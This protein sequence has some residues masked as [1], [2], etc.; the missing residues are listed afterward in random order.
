MTNRVIKELTDLSQEKDTKVT[1]EAAETAAE[2]ANPEIEQLKA[3][4]EQLKKQLAEE[5]E[6]GLRVRAEYDN[7]RKRT[8]REMGEINANVRCETITEILPIAD[9]IERALACPEGNEA[10][11]R[12]GVSMIQMQ[13]DNVFTKM[14]IEPIAAENVPFDPNVHNAVMHVE[15]D[16]ITESTVTQVFQKGYKLGNKVLRYAMVKVAN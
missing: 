1:A 14:N 4:I 10:E 5:K 3:E 16:A 12:K 6:L 15:D 11:L 9:N 13:I 2:A 7:Y 8:A